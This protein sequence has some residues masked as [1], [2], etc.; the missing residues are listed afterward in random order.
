M[1]NPNEK[2]FFIPL[3]SARASSLFFFN[4]RAQMSF[5]IVALRSDTCSF[6]LLWF[7]LYCARSTK[8]F[9]LCAKVC[10]VSTYQKNWRDFSQGSQCS[11][12]TRAKC[13]NGLF[14]S[15]WAWCWG[16]MH[17]ATLGLQSRNPSAEP[18]KSEGLLWLQK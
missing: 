6:M 8:V 13:V 12:G 10:E 17:P 16:K 15:N 11:Q 7:V 1:R 18:S 14:L 2:L 9:L 4:G 3:T 5:I